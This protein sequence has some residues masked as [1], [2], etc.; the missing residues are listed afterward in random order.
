MVRPVQE[1]TKLAI[2]FVKSMPSAGGYT[3]IA[4]RTICFLTHHYKFSSANGVVG[5]LLGGMTLFFEPT[6]WQSEISN[7]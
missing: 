7:T 3:M 4:R 2:A 1:L 5:A 6:G